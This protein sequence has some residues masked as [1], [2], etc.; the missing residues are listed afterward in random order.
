VR[1]IFINR[2][3]YPDHSATSQMLT[4]L[5]FG[6]AGKGFDVTIIT[7]RLRYEPGTQLAAR[8]MANGVRIER[9]WTSKFGRGGLAF[10]A[11]DY[12]T[13]YLAVAWALARF[14]RRDDVVVA[15]TDPPAVS[16]VA[17]IIARWRGARLVNWLQDVFP[18]VAEALKVGRE[19]SNVVFAPLRAVR[20]A[21]LRCADMNAAIGELMAERLVSLGV[22]RNRIAVIS[23]WADTDAIRPLAVAQNKY[24]SDWNLTGKFVIA[25]SGNLG[26]AHD[27]ETL[28]GAIAV[29]AKP[30]ARAAGV[31]WLFIGGGARY[32]QLKR[33]TERQGYDNVVFHPY[34]SRDAL[35]ESL[36]VA[37]VHIVSLLPELE[38]LIVPSKIYGIAA[39][40]RPAIFIGCPKGEVARLITQYDCGAV[41][42]IGD[43]LALVETINAFA[44][45]RDLC[46]AMG[47]RAR[48]MCEENFNKTKAIATWQR[49]IEATARSVAVDES[50]FTVF[51][52]AMPPTADRQESSRAP[53]G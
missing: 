18:E 17:A 2:F 44:R 16:V 36:S 48:A 53:A 14:A 41:V 50:A 33:E 13:F 20:N 52:P 37:D 30:P 12:L 28:L 25:Y 11:I 19:A 10:R 27:I 7:S 49:L 23:N 8:E 43:V 1:L 32:Q 29:M 47:D 38:G 45:D 15:M 22:K 4:D 24:R 31:C 21:S 9:I 5:A 3:F 46:R 39:A 42:A 26:R 6:L 40:G 34:Q 51:T 35:A